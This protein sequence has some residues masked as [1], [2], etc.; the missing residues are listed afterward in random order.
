VS[1]AVFRF[2]LLAGSLAAGAESAPVSA[3]P[4]PPTP[5]DDS[6][7]VGGWLIEHVAEEDGGRMVRLVRTRKGYRL[8]YHVAFWR[9]NAGPLSGVS[10]ERR[11]RSC[12]SESWRRDPA[13]NVWRAETD[14]A[15]AAGAVR[16]RLA[17][18]LAECGRR[19]GQADA[20]LAG[21]ERAF[22]YAWAWTEIARLAT[23]T[24]AEAIANEDRDTDAAPDA[25]PP[26]PPEPD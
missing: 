10:V 15:A 5:P 25:D 20:T 2:A 3:Q 4:F 1:R 21:F 11:G 13:G 12:A 16:A 14:L 26:P 9:G 6:H 23:Q 8:A 7:K 19:P 24:E 17:N 18:A 22:P